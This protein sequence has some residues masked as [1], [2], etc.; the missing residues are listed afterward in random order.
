[1]TNPPTSCAVTGQGGANNG[2]VAGYYYQDNSYTGLGHRMMI[3][4][5]AEESRKK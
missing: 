3:A 5:G 1:V 2:N 4:G